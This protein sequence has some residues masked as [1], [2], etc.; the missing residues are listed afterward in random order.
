[1]M[2]VILYSPQGKEIKEFTADGIGQFLGFRSEVEFHNE[3]SSGSWNRILKTTLPFLAKEPAEPRRT[4]FFEYRY[5]EEIQ[6]YSPNGYVL[7]VFDACQVESA[8]GV[9]KF[10]T[11]EYYYQTTLAYLIDGKL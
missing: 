10:F 11:E 6:L 5:D 7:H 4:G 9:T 3:T 1:M 2:D 8:S